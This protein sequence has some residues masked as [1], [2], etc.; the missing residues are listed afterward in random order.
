[1]VVSVEA[2]SAVTAYVA[3]LVGT[4]KDPLYFTLETVPATEPAVTVAAWG[5]PL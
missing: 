2:K 3:A 1:M 5:D 4:V